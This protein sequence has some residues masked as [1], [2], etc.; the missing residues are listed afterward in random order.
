MWTLSSAIRFVVLCL[1]LCQTG[2]TTMETVRSLSMPDLT[3]GSVNSLNGEVGDLKHTVSLMEKRFDENQKER[4]RSLNQL[5]A[6]VKE[7][8][9]AL[10]ERERRIQGNLGTLGT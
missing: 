6:L 7:S 5:R 10:E 4:Q 3:L 2:C 1:I 9:T 8:S